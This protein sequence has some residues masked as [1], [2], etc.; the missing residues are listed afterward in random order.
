[1]RKWKKQRLETL[2]RATKA[3][4]REWGN[5]LDP[6]ELRAQV[7]ARLEADPAGE[8]GLQ[9][10]ALEEPNVPAIALAGAAAAVVALGVSNLF[11]LIELWRSIGALGLAQY[12]QLLDPAAAVLGILF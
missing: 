9:S 3:H 12:I 5:T 11:S 7:M 2:L 6:R 10:D 4:Y 1:M 8:H